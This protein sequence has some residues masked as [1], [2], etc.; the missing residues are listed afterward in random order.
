MYEPSR[1]DAGPLAELTVRQ[2][3]KSRST[4]VVEGELL[5]ANEN[6]LVLLVT[7]DGELDAR[8]TRIPFDLI[9]RG[10][11]DDL[12]HLF[13]G[14]GRPFTDSKKESLRL[15][16]RY[17]GGEESAAFQKFMAHIGQE[18]IDTIVYEQ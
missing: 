15:I 6:S 8:I 5:T 7:P 1:I 17:P 10:K 3:P 13:I 14:N 12:P 4:Y 11:F 2:K 9:S 16:S 18:E